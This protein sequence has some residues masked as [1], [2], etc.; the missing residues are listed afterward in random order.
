MHTVNGKLIVE[1]PPELDHLMQNVENLAQ[2]FEGLESQMTTMSQKDKTEYLKQVVS[3]QLTL[4][5]LERTYRRL[6]YITVL[7]AIALASW[8]FGPSSNH[9]SDIVKSHSKTAIASTKSHTNR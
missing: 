3:V 1:A 4:Q 8:Y 7:T 5:K 2:Q 6:L 9:H